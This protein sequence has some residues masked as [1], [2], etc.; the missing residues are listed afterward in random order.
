MCLSQSP[1]DERHFADWLLDVGHGRTIE[2]DGTI[3]FD[4]DML[5]CGIYPN[6]NKV[7]PPLLYFLDH[8]ILTPR[9]SDVNNLNSDS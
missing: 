7:I 4:V 1:T 3:P 5:I 8:I 2:H 6:I 9:N